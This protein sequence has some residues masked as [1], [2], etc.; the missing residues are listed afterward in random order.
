MPSSEIESPQY[1]FCSSTFVKF[2]AE[3]LLL[4]M[5][6]GEE[7]ANFFG[8]NETVVSTSERLSVQDVIPRACGLLFHFYSVSA[9]AAIV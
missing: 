6:V 3:Y 5:S 1:P 7:S 9:F 8:K 4:L 2:V